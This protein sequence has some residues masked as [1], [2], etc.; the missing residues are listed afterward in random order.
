MCELLEGNEPRGTE[1]NCSG[2]SELSR[3][4][5]GSQNSPAQ[6]GYVRVRSTGLWWDGRSSSGKEM[7]ELTAAARS[8][9]HN[10]LSSPAC[11]KQPD[12]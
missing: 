7:I 4:W 8:L 9:P 3:G 11:S 1:G 5:K 10:S 12:F 6:L 2:E